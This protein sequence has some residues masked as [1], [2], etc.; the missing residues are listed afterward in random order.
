M[1]YFIIFLMSVL[2]VFWYRKLALKMGIMDEPNH[3]TSHQHNTPRGGGVI[4]VLLWL[5]AVVLTY[6]S[7]ITAYETMRVLVIPTLLVAFVSFV[8]DYFKIRR[9]Y[10]LISHFIAA[11]L[12][13]YLMTA[14]MSFVGSTLGLLTLFILTFYIVWSVN[15]FNFMDGLDGL[16]SVQSI[17]I[18][19]TSGCLLYI[20]GQNDLA[21]LSCLLS[22]SVLGFLVWNWPSAEIFMGD[23]GSTSLG[24]IYAIFTILSA[25]RAA[26]PIIIYLMLALPF[27]FDATMT[28]MRR[29]FAGAKWY[30]AHNQHAFQRLYHAGWSHKKVLCGLISLNIMGTLFVVMSVY[31]PKYL[32]SYFIFDLLM[33]SYVYYVI[34]CVRPMRCT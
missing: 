4:F 11:S 14:Q 30:E 27:I 17:F 20:K 12:V 15:L 25:K 10:R 9:R 3:R 32:Y 7:K 34:E 22:F 5:S 8:D 26:L 29:A 16:A 13:L 33:V 19:F 18:F 2:L 24:L 23:V 31:F 28:L 21:F 1:S 6:F